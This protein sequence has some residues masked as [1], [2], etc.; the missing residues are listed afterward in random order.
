MKFTLKVHQFKYQQARDEKAANAQAWA[1]LNK[2]L[3]YTAKSIRA[4]HPHQR[5]SIVIILLV[6]QDAIRQ[7][8]E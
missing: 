5:A 4:I 7:V 8:I 1:A 2:S 3:K 6:G